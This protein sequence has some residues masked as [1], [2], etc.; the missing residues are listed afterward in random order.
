MFATPH[1][2]WRLKKNECVQDDKLSQSDYYPCNLYW[3][4]TQCPT[5]MNNWYSQVKNENIYLVIKETV[6]VQKKQLEGQSGSAGRE[7][8]LLEGSVKACNTPAV[9]WV[10]R[11]Q[12]GH[13]RS[14][15]QALR[16]AFHN[17]STSSSDFSFLEVPLSA[18]PTFLGAFKQ[19]K[20]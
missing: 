2:R 6:K 9:P 1:K 3:K 7:R 12:Q 10:L 15:Y 4:A 8:H 14:V 20:L 16:M 19:L 5:Y 17:Y 11:S 18:V 13:W